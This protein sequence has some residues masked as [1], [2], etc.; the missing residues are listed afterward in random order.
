MS[1]KSRVAIVLVNAIMIGVHEV[2]GNNQNSPSDTN[3]RNRQAEVRL[4]KSAAVGFRIN[5]ARRALAEYCRCR[6]YILEDPR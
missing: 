3:D 4:E 5:Q 2:Y 6:V 1:C